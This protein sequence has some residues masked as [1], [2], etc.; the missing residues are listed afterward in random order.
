[1]ELAVREARRAAELLP[2]I[3]DSINGEIIIENS[4]LTHAWLGENA[5]ALAEL[6]TAARLPGGLSY[7]LL[8][9]HPTWDP[10]R[11]D[12]RFEKIVASF[13]PDAKAH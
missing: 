8:K 13:A 6:E 12:Q 10:L 7:G 9:L 2:V 4:A 11:G 5:V 1:M 3:N